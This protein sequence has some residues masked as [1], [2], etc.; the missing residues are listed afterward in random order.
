MASQQS[1]IQYGPAFPA[2]R[3]MFQISNEREM[4]SYNYLKHG[5]DFTGSYMDGRFDLKLGQLPPNGS[6]L[7]VFDVSFLFM[8]RNLV[9]PRFVSSGADL[10][11]LRPNLTSLVLS[12]NQINLT[13]LVVSCNQIKLTNTWHFAPTDSVVIL[14]NCTYIFVKHIWSREWINKM[15]VW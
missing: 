9:S 4:I 11:N 1:I 10:A 12:C 6:S 15:H 13:S 5:L 14:Q 7:G 3:Q 8:N 2:R